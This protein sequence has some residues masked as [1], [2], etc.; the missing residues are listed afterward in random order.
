[1]KKLGIRPIDELFSHVFYGLDNKS[2]PVNVTNKFLPPHALPWISSLLKKYE[3]N[4]SRLGKIVETLR[5]YS[6]VNVDTLYQ[7]FHFKDNSQQLHQPFSVEY[8]FSGSE[9]NAVESPYLPLQPKTFY[10]VE[11]ADSLG[12]IVQDIVKFAFG[13]K[14]PPQEA[15]KLLKVFLKKSARPDAAKNMESIVEDVLDCFEDIKIDLESNVNKSKFEILAKNVENKAKEPRTEKIWYENG[16]G[17]MVFIERIVSDIEQVVELQ[18]EIPLSRK[19]GRWGEEWVNSHLHQKYPDHEIIWHNESFESGYA[20]DFEIRKNGS[21]LHHIEVKSTKESDPTTE[22][23]LSQNE[24]DMAIQ[25][26]KQYHIYLVLGYPSSP[27]LHILID[28]FSLF[29]ARKLTIYTTDK[30]KV[31]INNDLFTQYKTLLIL[32]LPYPNSQNFYI[33]MTNY[34]QLL[35]LNSNLLYSEI[36]TPLHNTQLLDAPIPTD[37]TLFPHYTH[38]LHSLSSF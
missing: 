2:N 29:L 13:V 8:Y 24:W 34:T 32:F 18:P 19:I 21:L 12:Y 10:I 23:F 3:T 5:R 30:Y 20:A 4:D 28:P 7:I 22:L 6:V 14:E 11:S 35:S 1:M 38:S 16:L 26:R 9:N 15:L 33:S 27:S 36:S 25:H 31:A 37:D 17:E